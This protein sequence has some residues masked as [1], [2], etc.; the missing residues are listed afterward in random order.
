MRRN[1]DIEGLKA[2]NISSRHRSM[3]P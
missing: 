2:D 1:T 3:S